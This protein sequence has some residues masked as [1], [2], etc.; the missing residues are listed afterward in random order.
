MVRAG[1][2]SMVG[3]IVAC[4]RLDVESQGVELVRNHPEAYRSNH[5]VSNNVSL[6]T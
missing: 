5:E 2:S 1:G 6:S 3:D 4:C